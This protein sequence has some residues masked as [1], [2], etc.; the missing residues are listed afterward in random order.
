VTIAAEPEVLEL[1]PDDNGRLLTPEEFDV[2]LFEDGWSYELVRGVL[3]VSPAPSRKERDPNGELERMLRNYQEEHPR[4]HVLNATFSEE[5]IFVGDQRRRADR[6]IWAGLGRLPAPTEPPTI[7]VEFVSAGRR[8]RRRDYEEKRS[9]YLA[10]GVREYWVIDRFRRTLTVFAPT[11]A[12]H[13]TTTVSEDQVYTT[14]L[15]PGFELPLARLLQ[16]A[17]R[18]ED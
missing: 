1:G 4:G 11:A 9:E 7:I 5:M 12:G 10:I 6:A 2:A 16:L 8:S 14:P 18:W 15:L 17:D 13:R 3:I